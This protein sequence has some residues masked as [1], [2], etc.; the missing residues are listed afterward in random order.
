METQLVSFKGQIHFRTKGFCLDFM[1]SVAC[2]EGISLKPIRPYLNDLKCMTEVHLGHV[3]L[4][5][6]T[7]H[8][9]V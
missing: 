4:C 8:I 7:W 6:C 1:S 2:N 9:A 5:T 3:H